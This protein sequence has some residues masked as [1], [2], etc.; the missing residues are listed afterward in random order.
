MQ[1]AESGVGGTATLSGRAAEAVSSYHA[2]LAAD[3]ELARETS[4]ALV[5]AHHDRRLMMQGRL[6]CNVLRPRFLD[7]SASNA[8]GLAAAAIAGILERAGEAMLRSGGQLRSIGASDVEQEIWSIDPGYA[9]LTLTS[10]LD[11]FIAAG[12][13]RFIEYN[14]ESPAGIGY[15]DSLTEVFHRL[16]AMQRWV[17]HRGFEPQNARRRLWESLLAAYRQWGGTDTPRIA[18]VDWQ[19][20]P[21]KRDFELCAEYFRDQG[22]WVGISDPRALTYRRGQVF[23]GDDRITLVYRRVLL[24]EL[25]A[26]AS[27]ARALLYAYRD[28][29]VC[30]VNSPRSKLLHKKTVFALLSEGALGVDLDHGERDLVETVIPWTRRLALGRTT[31]DG[32]EIDLRQALIDD[33]ERFAVKPVDDYGGK[34][35]VL[36]WETD[37]E[38]WKRLVNNSPES[39]Y[40]VQERVEVPQEEFPVYR[41]GSLHL[42]SLSVDTD[43]L[44]FRGEMGSI[45]TRMSGSALLNVTAGSGSTTPTFVLEEDG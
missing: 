2:A 41:D 43:P 35:V 42:E 23:L 27:D 39:A 37:P 40:I 9:G 1:Q 26:R 16:P 3:T 6:L 31:L 20:V 38:H 8:L 21:T 4:E 30:M 15:C 22:A 12:R 34:G 29:A 7:A 18:I 17:A 25:L 10:R 5:R 13:I 28:G 11:A 45:L 44:L 19:D 24:H 32:R 33:P 14:A 36:G